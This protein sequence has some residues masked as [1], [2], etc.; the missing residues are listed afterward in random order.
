[1]CCIWQRTVLYARN[2]GIAHPQGHI[3]ELTHDNV[4]NVTFWRLAQNPDMRRL[5]ELGALL[6]EVRPEIA[7]P[8]HSA[9]P[10][11]ALTWIGSRAGRLSD[12]Q[13]RLFEE[14]RWALGYWLPGPYEVAPTIN[15]VVEGLIA[16]LPSPTRR[17]IALRPQPADASVLDAPDEERMAPSDPPPNYLAIVEEAIRHGE[18]GDLAAAEAMLLPLVEAH[19]E[20]ALGHLTLAETLQKR[21]EYREALLHY[22]V[23]G[24]IGVSY[25][26]VRAGLA[27]CS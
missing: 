20:N 21:G 10:H 13:R 6:Q 17:S 7:G 23:A 25:E 5:P 24:A 27:F 4:G 18:A 14:L 12:S 15:R 19:P 26:D 9:D 8:L 3:V 16:L 11:L 22:R 2:K 1:M